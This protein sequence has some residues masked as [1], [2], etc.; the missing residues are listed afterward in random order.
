[1]NFVVG[2]K[3]PEHWTK[4]LFVSKD[5]SRVVA[6]QTGFC[7]CMISLAV[8]GSA[9]GFNLQALIGDEVKYWDEAKFK[10]EVKPAIRG[11]KNIS[12]TWLNFKASGFSPTSFQAR[13]PM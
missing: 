11:A 5:W 8:Q 10:S 7:V 12:G 1:M 3:P 13:A 9:N 6:F 4:P 2:K